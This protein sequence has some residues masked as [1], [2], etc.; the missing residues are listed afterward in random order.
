MAQEA[1]RIG[2]WEWDFDTGAVRWSNTLYR[3]LGMILDNTPLKM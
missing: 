2:D 3:V 1:G